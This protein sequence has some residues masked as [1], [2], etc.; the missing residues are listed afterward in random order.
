[1]EREKT[2]QDIIMN[3][4]ID[5]KKMEMYPVYKVDET[6]NSAVEEKVREIKRLKWW[7]R[8]FNIF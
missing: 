6:I 1:M 4:I 8:L 5:A 3:Q 2:P 7:K